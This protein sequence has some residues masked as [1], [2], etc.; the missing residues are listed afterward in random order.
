MPESEPPSAL[1]GGL[2]VALLAAPGSDAEALAALRRGLQQQGVNVF[3]LSPDGPGGA[4][5][6][7]DQRLADADAMGFDG[8]LVV[9]GAEGVAHLRA[10]PDS[11]AFIREIHRDHK[12]LG[13]LGEGVLLLLDTGLAAGRRLCASPAMTGELVRAGARRVQGPVCVQ[14]R[15]ATATGIEA[16]DVFAAAF[17]DLLARR[18]RDG[19]A[20]EADNTPGA[21][22]EDG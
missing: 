1:L 5:P 22:G 21:V 14:A 13:A 16:L 7:A 9:G 10:A 2:H 8:A 17:Q 12:P 18:R 15:W 4:A 19:F 6:A 20:N 11:L 3:V